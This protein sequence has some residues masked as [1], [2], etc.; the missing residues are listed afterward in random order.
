M[1]I[2]F[3]VVEK[4]SSLLIIKGEEKVIDLSSQQDKNWF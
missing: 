1:F 3:K 2:I 4:E